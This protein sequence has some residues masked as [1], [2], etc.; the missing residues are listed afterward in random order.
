MVFQRYIVLGNSS[1]E[2]PLLS[3]LFWAKRASY[4]IVARVVVMDSTV[5]EAETIFPVIWALE[6]I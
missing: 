1:V 2:E 5:A 3:E 6:N 4:P